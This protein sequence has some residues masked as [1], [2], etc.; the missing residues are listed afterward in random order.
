[1]TTNRQHSNVNARNIVLEMLLDTDRGRKSHLVL[2]ETLD[3]SLMLDKQQRAFIT[4]LYHGTIE[5]RIEIDYIINLF[6]K[7]SINKMKPVIRNIIRMSVFQDHF[8]GGPT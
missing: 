6:S 7:I 4:R 8:P 3:K 5:R 2:K 1:M